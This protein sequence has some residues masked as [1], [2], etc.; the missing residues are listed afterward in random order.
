MNKLLAVLFCFMLWCA[1]TKVQRTTVLAPPTDV[2]GAYSVDWGAGV[3]GVGE[4]DGDAVRFKQYPCLPVGATDEIGGTFEYFPPD[5]TATIKSL[6][7]VTRIAIVGS[8]QGTTMHGNFEIRLLDV[9][10]TTGAITMERT[11]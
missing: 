2:S 11:Q 8:F 9:V 5:F 4:I 10:C 1:C 3:F 6:D 7:G